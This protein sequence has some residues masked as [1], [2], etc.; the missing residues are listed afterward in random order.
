VR[1]H[2]IAVSSL[3]APLVLVAACGN[4]DLGSR[5]YFE[6]R[7]APILEENCV[8]GTAEGLCHTESNEKPGEAL[9]NLDL[10]SF[11]AIHRRP[12]LLAAYGSYP[13]P[14]LLTKAAK[15]SVIT[16]IYA[17]ATYSG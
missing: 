7:I 17:G 2:N 16:M 6:R 3:A 8:R 11:E 5:T 14:V 9:G 15:P 13:D 10:S 12:E 1:T 4:P